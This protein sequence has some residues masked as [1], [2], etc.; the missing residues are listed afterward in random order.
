MGR[1]FMLNSFLIL[2]GPR[3]YVRPTKYGMG[4]SLR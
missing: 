1:D 4:L 3:D 2:S